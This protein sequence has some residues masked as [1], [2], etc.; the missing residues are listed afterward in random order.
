MD[1]IT[2]Y[3]GLRGEQFIELTTGMNIT[4]SSNH[5]LYTSLP[6]SQ[7]QADLCLD[8]E[9]MEQP[10]CQ[11]RDVVAGGSVGIVIIFALVVSVI[12]F[13]LFIKHTSCYDAFD[14]WI[15]DKV[16]QCCCRY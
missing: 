13:R 9:C 15:D 5:S 10:E 8:P 11:S 1:F 14:D 6:V 16:D 12:V 4:D 3:S 2:E 7:N